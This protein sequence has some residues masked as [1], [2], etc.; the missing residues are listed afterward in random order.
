MLAEKLRL[1]IERHPFDGVGAIRASLGVAE[2]LDGEPAEAWFRRVD[3]VL[4]AAKSDGRNRVHVD[5]RGASDMLAGKVLER[6]L[7][8]SNGAGAWNAT[9]R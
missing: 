3:D 6:L 8:G 2:H 4:Y 1:D 7:G 9:T 5:C